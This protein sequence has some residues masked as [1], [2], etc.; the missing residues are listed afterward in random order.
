VATGSAASG[1]TNIGIF[2]T[3]SS[4]ARRRS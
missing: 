1:V 4:P 2:S 3:I